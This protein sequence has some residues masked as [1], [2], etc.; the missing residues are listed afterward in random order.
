MGGNNGDCEIYKMEWTGSS[1]GDKLSDLLDS[2]SLTLS[3]IWMMEIPS[4]NL[5]LV[6][7][8]F[9]RFARFAASFSLM[10][11]FI[12]QTRRKFEEPR[13]SRIR[14]IFKVQ[15]QRRVISLVRVALNFT[16]P[17]VPHP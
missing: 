13:I 5:P 12:F 8:K 15:Y 11:E 14:R 10:L 2:A 4:H 7:D 9:A 17:V 6:L 3:P 1:L 16:I